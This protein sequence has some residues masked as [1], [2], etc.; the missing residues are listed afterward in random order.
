[1][2]KLVFLTMMFGLIMVLSGSVS[3]QVT[4]KVNNIDGSGKLKPVVGDN[5]IALL[6]KPTL[7][8]PA[9]GVKKGQSYC[10]LVIKRGQGQA[11][12]AFLNMD[13]SKRTA[14]R[15]DV[16]I[17]KVE[18]P[19]NADIIIGDNVKIDEA[20]KTITFSRGKISIKLTYQ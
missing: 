17:V 15:N 4:G 20:A 6:V 19:S 12:S 9:F 5:A 13:C 7:D 16:K 14:L 8:S 11:V 1:M 18:N 3:A 10:A 2:K